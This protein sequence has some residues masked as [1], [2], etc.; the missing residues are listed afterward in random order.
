MEVL[1]STGPT[2][3]SFSEFAS[4]QRVVPFSKIIFHVV[5]CCVHIVWQLSVWGVMLTKCI[6]G[7]GLMA[8]G[9]DCQIDEGRT[10]LPAWDFPPSL[11]YWFANTNRAKPSTLFLYC[12]LLISL[13][14]A[15]LYL[16]SG[17]WRWQL[18]TA[19]F[20]LSGLGQLLHSGKR[21]LNNRAGRLL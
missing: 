7:D 1:L 13:L 6:P 19:K 3:S 14:A 12:K 15:S 10:Y 4:Y 16:L 11:L 8:V 21:R 5:L 9:T 20:S 2:P 18:T 17:P